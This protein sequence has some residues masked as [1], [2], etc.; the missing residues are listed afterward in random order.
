[1]GL[2]TFIVYYN[3]INL[4][5]SWIANQQSHWLTHMLALHGSLTLGAMLL[6]QVRHHHWHWRWWPSKGLS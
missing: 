2:F 5:Q 4:G 6:L 1:L 3:L